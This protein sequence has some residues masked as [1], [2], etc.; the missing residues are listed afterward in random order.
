[1]LLSD[2]PLQ[3]QV[4]QLSSLQ[5]EDLSEALVDFAT[6]TDLQAWLEANFAQE[7]R[8]IRD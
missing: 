3:A 2:E 7:Q 4:R 8:E 1:V 5:L 6:P